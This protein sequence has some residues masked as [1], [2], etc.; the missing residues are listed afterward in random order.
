MVN[1]RVKLAMA[2][3]GT[4]DAAS[5]F[6]S[7]LQVY[8]N[9]AEVS[10]L[11]TGSH[12]LDQLLSGIEPT[13]FYLFFGNPKERAPDRLLY[14]LMVE[15]VKPGEASGQ[16]VYLLCGN[17]RRDR[18][19]LDSELLLSLLEDS[20]LELDDALGRIHIIGVFSEAQLM[21]APDLVEELVREHDDIKLLAVQQI[22]KLFYGEKAI[23]HE[24]PAEFTGVV[25]RLK[26]IC[27]L[28]GI[29]MVASCESKRR[30]RLIPEPKGGNFLRHSANVITYLRV[31]KG[32]D[33]SA[34]LVKH[35]D[36]DRNGKRV[37]FSGEDDVL[38]RITKDS[39]RG[40]IQ[41]AMTHLR[42][43]YREALKDDDLQAAFDLVWETW[44]L[45]QGAMIYA[46]VVSSMDLLNLTGAVSN[47]REIEELRRRVDE[48]ERK[49]AS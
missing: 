43:G 1:C 26:E 31:M 13:M 37:S 10:R 9:R 32:G 46:Q 44:N 41:N 11:S 45:E 48:L 34:Q 14:R 27:T 23:R 29:A 33:V 35:F 38:G 28:H 4:L 19:T 12:R 6:K 5:T 16:V 15:A 17:Y 24:N 25:S 42:T 7:A 49:D 47:R 39:M 40:R 22:S 2:D 30:R 18:T 8:S 3:H 21:N 36:K 20:G